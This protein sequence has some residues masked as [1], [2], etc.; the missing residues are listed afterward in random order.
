M[1]LNV[2]VQAF[3]YTALILS[4]AVGV[5]AAVAVC[6]AAVL[7]VLAV[8]AVS[9]DRLTDWMAKRWQRK[10]KQP[11]GRVARIIYAGRDNHV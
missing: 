3:T 10:G 6:G 2:F 1:M 11:R 5:C 4:G 8:L 7:V 9:F